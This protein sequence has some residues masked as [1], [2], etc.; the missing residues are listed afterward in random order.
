[1]EIL[2][3][4]LFLAMGSS[5][6]YLWGL[7]VESKILKKMTVL[8]LVLWIG[9]NHDIL[10]PLTSV[11]SRLSVIKARIDNT[12]QHIQGSFASTL[13]CIESLDSIQ[14][15]PLRVLRKVMLRMT[16]SCPLQ[17]S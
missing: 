13:Y 15:T 7:R 5:T 11:S 14:L 12:E 17:S 10:S 16:P 1:M 3:V 8:L 6:K 2:K 4:F 9:I